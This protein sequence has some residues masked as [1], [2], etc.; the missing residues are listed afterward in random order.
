[1]IIVFACDGLLVTQ[2]FVCLW[3]CTVFLLHPRLSSN[4]NMCT[5]DD[6]TLIVY[7]TYAVCGIAILG[8]LGS[9]YLI[10]HVWS[11]RAHPF[12]KTRKPRLTYAVLWIFFSLLL[13]S[14]L[15]ALLYHLWD[16]WD[17]RIFLVVDDIVQYGCTLAY[18]TRFEHGADTPFVADRV[19]TLC[20]LRIS[21]RG[22][23]TTTSSGATRS[24]T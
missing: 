12:I 17:H 7:I 2:F 21:E 15:N 3:N 10:V 23:C 13:L 1:M 6:Q 5:E 9:I 22:S 18:A 14:T 16:S 11:F 8:D 4:L 19:P 24:G 20:V